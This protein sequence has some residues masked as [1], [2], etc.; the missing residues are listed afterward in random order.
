MIQLVDDSSY[1]S[2][3]AKERLRKSRSPAKSKKMEAEM[4]HRSPQAG[5]NFILKEKVFTIM[6][7]ILI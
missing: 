7:L 5:N 6:G 3:Y 1:T 2:E 4:S